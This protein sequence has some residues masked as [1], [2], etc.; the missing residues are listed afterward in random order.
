MPQIFYNADGTPVDWEAVDA[1]DIP[2]DVV[3]KNPLF[4]K[5]LDESKQRKETIKALRAGQQKPASEQ[6]DDDAEDTPAKTPVT[7]QAAP[8]PAVDINAVYQEVATRLQRDNEAAARAQADQAALVTR[9]MTEESLD[10][11]NAA[12]RSLLAPK[13]ADMSEAAVRERAKTLAQAGLKFDR[14]PAGDG[15]NAGAMLEV[16]AKVD[17]N[18]G[19]KPKV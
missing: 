1:N 3:K 6:S 13:G 8:V 17:A 5:V 9:I 7:S 11:N 10:E 19:L 2:A 15:K 4:N 18:L 12:V 14:V 16:F